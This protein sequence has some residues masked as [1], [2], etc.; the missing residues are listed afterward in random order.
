MSYINVEYKRNNLS[1]SYINCI[2]C[3]NLIDIKLFDKES[4]NYSGFCK[5]CIL[6]SVP[7]GY[8]IC[9]NCQK[10]NKYNGYERKIKNNIIL[11][12][13]DICK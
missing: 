10:T 11:Y 8:Y 3:N 12:L 7:S 2:H 1:K 9:N 4:K 6:L 5:Q 13:C